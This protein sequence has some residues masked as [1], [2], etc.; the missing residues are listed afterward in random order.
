MDSGE[1]RGNLNQLWVGGV[2]AACTGRTA[3]S[4]MGA[5]NAACDGHHPIGE[6][7]TSSFAALAPRLQFSITMAQLGRW[8]ATLRRGA[9]TRSVPTTGTRL[10]ALRL[11]ANQSA[12]AGVG[13]R[14]S[15][16]EEILKAWNQ[17]MV[18]T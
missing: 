4:R 5:F 12:K 15:R 8:G 18:C 11:Y 1:Q 14:D 13:P 2:L 6:L 16:Q 17:C 9:C 7:N 3:P 10:G